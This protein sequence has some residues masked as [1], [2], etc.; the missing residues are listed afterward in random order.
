M[1]LQLEQTLYVRS[2]HES[3]DMLR[4]TLGFLDSVDHYVVCTRCLTPPGPAEE[5]A[6]R[7]RR[8]H[9]AHTISDL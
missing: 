2:T 1:T 5:G 3:I 9:G 8:S 4:F 7:D 6:R